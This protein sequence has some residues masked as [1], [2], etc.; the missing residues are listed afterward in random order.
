MQVACPVGKL[1]VTDSGLTL[2]QGHVFA[3]D[4]RAL[5]IMIAFKL[6][7]LLTDSIP[8]NVRIIL[9]CSTRVLLLSYYLL[10]PIDQVCSVF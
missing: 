6:A 9:I 5:L 4:P 2:A 3:T 7:N 1:V 10:L 8:M